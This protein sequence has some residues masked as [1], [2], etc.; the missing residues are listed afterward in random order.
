MASD[1]STYVRELLEGTREPLSTEQ[2]VAALRS[3]N[4]KKAAIKG[5]EHWRTSG[6]AVQDADGLWVWI[7]PRW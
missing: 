5:L 3:A 6:E 1:A 7:G 4:D 2:V